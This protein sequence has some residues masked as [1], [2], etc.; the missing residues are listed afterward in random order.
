LKQ[1]KRYWV[2]NNL[3]ALIPNLTEWSANY[4]PLDDK[5]VPQR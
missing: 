3:I 4:Q 5:K 1:P 2:L